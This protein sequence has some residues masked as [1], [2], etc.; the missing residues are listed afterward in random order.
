MM[1]RPPVINKMDFARR[2]SEGEFGNASPTWNTDKAYL[3]DGYCGPVHIRNKVVGAQTWYN[4]NRADFADYWQEACVKFGADMLYISAMAPTHL[5]RLQG[6]VMR[7][8]G[9][10]YL[11]YST[12]VATMRDALATYSQDV[13]GLRAK[14][15]LQLEMCWNSYDWLCQLLD[16]Y[17][18]HVVEFSVYAKPWG[19]IPKYNTVFWEVRKGY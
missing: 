15:L 19:T 9:G 11:H 2:F 1:Y 4:V 17:P 3:K 18:D 10:L 13:R 12:V 8:P 7:E 16:W 6:E 14:H 5:T